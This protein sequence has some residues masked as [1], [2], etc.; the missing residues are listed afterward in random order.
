MPHQFD[1]EAVGF[2]DTPE[3]LALETRIEAQLLRSHDNGT[4]P[5]LAATAVG[6]PSDGTA[7]ADAR[8]A[9]WCAQR[10]VAHT[11][12]LA[13]VQA[14]RGHDYYT[15]PFVRLVTTARNDRDGKKADV[16][17]TR[18]L[19]LTVCVCAFINPNRGALL[20]WRQRVRAG[21]VPGMHPRDARTPHYAFL[22]DPRAADCP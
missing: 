2:W 7:A 12:A 1:R 21:C 5:T 13:N 20:L 4:L 22:A 17:S 15:V 16:I 14:L 8:K 3:M 19:G 18:S 6:K 10:R 11:Q 9:G